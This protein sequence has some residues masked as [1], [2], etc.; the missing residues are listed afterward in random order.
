V[1]SAR[2]K[3]SRGTGPFWAASAVLVVLAAAL[4]LL[5]Q[6]PR[7]FFHGDTQSAYLGWEYR[8]GEQLRAG[9]WP[10]V[11]L[12]AWASGNAMAEGQWALFN[13]LLAAIGLLATTAQNVLVFATAVKV[14]LACVGVLGTYALSRSYGAAAPLAFVAAV[15]A[16]F[17]GMTQYLD[18]ASWTAGLMIWALVPWVWWAL[19]RTMIGAANPA[20]LLVLVYLL[21]TV[22]YV[23]GTIMLGLVLAV[24]LVD[25]RVHRDRTAG[26]RVV[27]TGVFGGLVACT[28]YLP[29]VLTAPVTIRG[30]GSFHVEGKFA[31][32]P[33]ALLASPLVTDAVPGTTLHLLPY[34]FVAW[35]LPVMLL[36]DVGALRR[37]WQPVAGLLVFTAVMVLVVVAMPQ[38][39]GPLRWPLR[40]QPFLVQ[41]V[42]ALT[43]VLVSRYVVRRP[44]RRRLELGLAWLVL[45]GLTAAARAPGLWPAH[46]LA[47]VG[48]AAGF[49]AVWWCLGRPGA[50]SLR[51]GAL[52][53]A[54]LTVLLGL[55]QHVVFP[56]PPSP[57]R[58]MPALAR[59]YRLQVPAAEGDVLVVGD[60]GAALEADPAWA[61]E[62]LSGSAW[63][64]GPHRVQNGY[65]TISFRAYRDR[66]C[67][68][69]DGST[70]P[71]LLDELFS[72]EPTTGMRR[73][74]LLSVGTLLLVRSDFPERDLTSPPTGWRV[75]AETSRTVTWVRRTPAPGAGRPVWTSAGTTVVPRP[76]D[77]RSV[78]FTVQHVPATGG[79][80]VIAAMAW[81]GFATDVGRVA[82]PVDGYLL[83][84]DLPAG[85]TGRTVTVRF[86][87]PGWPLELVTLGLAVVGGVAW[88]GARVVSR[89]RRR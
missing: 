38:Q 37:R 58:H 89:R 36:V 69:Y 49:V 20:A 72:T 33:L 67:I 85:A 43:A 53:A 78:R 63:Y 45:A 44:S 29:G 27:G 76:G 8:L 50:V 35:F 87:P 19:R 46:V 21:V 32:D 11:D 42:V 79:R 39:V 83:T 12:H 73:V 9:R 62:S 2:G 88:S 48:A 81:P 24:S 54:G 7:Y 65:T 56:V 77:D 6:D 30:G 14:A 1:R 31:S 4:L 25:A 75:A 40:L 13:P 52:A 86:S 70:C 82:T 47:L 41:A 28:V 68:D 74:D 60:T 34:A 26:R 23:Y 15:A 57:E 64:L 22:G 61:R 17:G 84:V 18:L 10:L 66:Y 16:V 59:D 71:R 55:L 5:V 3:A 51:A 80:V